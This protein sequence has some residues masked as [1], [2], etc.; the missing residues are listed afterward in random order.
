MLLFKIDLDFLVLILNYWYKILEAFSIP[1]IFFFTQTDDTQR[2]ICQQWLEGINITNLSTSFWGPTLDAF[3]HHTYIQSNKQ[4][5]FLDFQGM[6][7]I[8]LFRQLTLDKIRHNN[9]LKSFYLW[10]WNSQVRHDPL[11]TLNWTNIV[12]YFRLD[13]DSEQQF[14]NGNNT[15]LLTCEQTHQCNSLCEDLLY[16]FFWLLQIFAYLLLILLWLFSFLTTLNNLHLCF[17][18]LFSIL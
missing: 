6:L 15:L 5:V 12:V 14:L 13:S 3:S 1:Q 17:T 9:Q 8:F 10:L 18:N 2:Y 16:N 7:L 11:T 4:F